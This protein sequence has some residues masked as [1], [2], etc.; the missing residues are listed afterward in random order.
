MAIRWF[1]RRTRVEL[2]K[3][4]WCVAESALDTKV[5]SVLHAALL[6]GSVLFSSGERVA[7]LPLVGTIVRAKE[8][9][10]PRFDW[11]HVLLLIPCDASAL[12]TLIHRLIFWS[13]NGSHNSQQARLAIHA[14]DKARLPM[15]S[16]SAPLFFWR[17]IRLGFC[18]FVFYKLLH[19]PFGSSYGQEQTIVTILVDMVKLYLKNTWFE[20]DFFVRNKNGLIRDLIHFFRG[21]TRPNLW[22]KLFFKTFFGVKKIEY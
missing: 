4:K 12:S 6:Y 11:V 20:I 3:V 5:I 13:F 15:I 2:V 10:R 21:S 19:I 18:L 8:K 9:L 16:W 1:K 7:T 14:G 22:P 17:I